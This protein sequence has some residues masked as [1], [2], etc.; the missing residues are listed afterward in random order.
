MFIH[1]GIYSL[2]GKGGSM[3]IRGQ[4]SRADYAA[5]AER[6]NPKRFDP[7]AWAERARE[8]G[9]K[10]MVFTTR[11]H[12]GFSMFGTRLSDLNS[13]KHAA[14]RDFVAEII[15]ACRKAGLKVGL[16]Y[17]L[18]DWRFRSGILGRRKAPRD[19]E[20]MVEFA[21]A[22]V[23]ELMTNYGRID[24][25]WYD[26][27]GPGWKSGK[28]NAMVRRLQPHILINDR[29]GS[30]EDFLTP[31]QKIEVPP[32]GRLWETCMTLN[33]NWGYSRDDHNW[34]RAE[35]L[36]W[37]LAVCSHNGGNLLLNVG[38]RA[39][40]AFPAKAVTLLERIG[41]W[42]RMHAEAIHGTD[43][44][45][46]NYCDQQI[47]TGRGNT[48]YLFLHPRNHPRDCLVLTGIANRVR[49]VRLMASGERL[50]VTGKENRFLIRLP[51]LGRKSVHVLKISLD[52][53]PKGVPRTYSED[54]AF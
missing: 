4:M 45:P 39:D 8:A 17:S 41:Q 42:M 54:L 53:P 40:G 52:S 48:V 35:D 38:P 43:P 26:G 44:Y 22:Q 49:R 12:D 3:R 47:T 29:S 36:V 20:R 1:W 28:L 19:W 37:T 6:F 50:Q 10:Y 15:R 16:Y 7:D 46:F 27:G 33:D 21:H 2:V 34:K 25:L 18:V 24:I 5:L 14:Q 9:M 32:Q 31:E 13:V 51:R 30:E 23:Q 11:H